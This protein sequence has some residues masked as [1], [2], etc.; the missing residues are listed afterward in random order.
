MSRRDE[1]LISNYEEASA[2]FEEFAH[3]II[4]EQVLKVIELLQANSSEGV[5]EIERQLEQSQA[6]CDSLEKDIEDF[7]DEVSD[8]KVEVAELKEKLKQIAFVAACSI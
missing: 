1:C 6:E 7:R 4:D 8:L 2:W 5:L 3:T